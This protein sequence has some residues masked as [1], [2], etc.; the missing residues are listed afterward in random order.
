MAFFTAGDLSFFLPSIYALS[1]SFG[2]SN[3]WYDDNFRFEW[4]PENS[5]IHGAHRNR[6]LMTLL[7]WF[8]RAKW[9]AFDWCWLAGHSSLFIISFTIT[10]FLS[11]IREWNVSSFIITKRWILIKM[12]SIDYLS[13]LIGHWLMKSIPFFC[14]R[15]IVG[16][17]DLLQRVCRIFA[18]S[19]R[20]FLFIVNR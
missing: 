16:Q 2:F 14:L 1:S 13:P 10:I 19:V 8:I 17:H 20:M 3:S 5:K 6:F 12:K 7:L 18:L 11:L 15:A 4:I 9:T